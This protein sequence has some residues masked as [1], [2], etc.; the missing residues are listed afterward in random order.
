M[1]KFVCKLDL[2]NVGMQD[3]QDIAVALH[4]LSVYI[5]DEKY[6]SG[7][8]KTRTGSLVGE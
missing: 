1:K 8:I 4:N 5:L 7:Q 6:L 3:R 2:E